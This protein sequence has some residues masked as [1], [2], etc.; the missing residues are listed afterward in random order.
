MW[1]TTDDIHY[2]DGRLRGTIILNP[3]GWPINVLGIERNPETRKFEVIGEKLKGEIKPYLLSDIN[4]TSPRLGYTNYDGNAFYLGRFPKRRDWKQGLRRENMFST[5]AVKKVKGYRFPNYVP[6]I[7]PLT[8][9]Y[10]SYHECLERVEDIYDSCSFSLL[11]AID[12]QRKLLYKNNEV[13]GVAE[14]DKPKLSEDFFWLNEA[15]QEAV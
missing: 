4:P 6:L 7:V 5:E 3:E 2:V 10:P 1:Y 8:G 13:V 9:K 15:L 14:D 11:F 12:K